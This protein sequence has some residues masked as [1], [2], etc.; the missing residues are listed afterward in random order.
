MATFTKLE[1]SPMFR[2]QVASLALRSSAHEASL[3]RPRRGNVSCFLGSRSVLRR[4]LDLGVSNGRIRS[5][6]GVWVVVTELWRIW[7]ILCAAD[8]D[9][10][11]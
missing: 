10:V 3:I 7:I 11:A 8:L 9:L 5:V 6:V 1:D 2:K 4:Q